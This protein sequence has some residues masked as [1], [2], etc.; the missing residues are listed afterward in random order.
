MKKSYQIIQVCVL[1]AWG[2]GSAQSWASGFALIEQNASGLG[3]AYAGAAAAAEDASTIYFNPAGLTRLPRG[4]FAGA[5]HAIVPSARFSNTA[6]ALAAP[7]ALNGTGGDAGSIAGVPNGYVSWQMGPSWWI[8]MGLSAP[9]GLKTEYDSNWMGRFQGVK[10]DIKTI[11]VNPTIAFKLSDTVSIGAGVSWQYID[12]E[13]TRAV[14]LGA[15]EGRAKIEA[16]DTQWGFNLGIMFNLS[17]N[18]RIGATYRSTMGYQLSGTATI[19]SAAGVPVAGTPVA[20]SANA[21]LPDTYSV[22]FNH[23]VDNRW[24]LLGDVTYTRWSTIK[25]V[26][27][28]RL[29]TGTPLDTF[30]LQFSDTWRAGIGA[31]YKLSEAFTLKFGLAYDKSPVSDV[32]R[33]VRLPDND[34]TWVSIGGKY[35]WSKATTLDFG[36]AHLFVKDGPIANLQGTAPG[37]NGNVIGNYKNQVNIVSVQ[38]SHG[39]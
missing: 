6:T 2:G 37:Q 33:T 38:F 28:I 29:D 23:A 36:Y 4:N 8:G 14:N 12:A 34:R 25:T 18:T 30:N 39:F 11:D 35:R 32:F 9:F 19:L 7:H 13:F 20:I 10:S 17:P 26:P 3:N 31:N 1:A 5:L 15:T 16:D 21:R 27:I 22:A 24:E